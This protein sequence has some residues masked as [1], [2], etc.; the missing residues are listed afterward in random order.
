VYPESAPQILL[1]IFFIV[2]T[3]LKGFFIV[4]EFMHLRFEF[5]A[6][7]ITILAPTAFLI[8]FIIA[9]LWEGASWLNLREVWSYF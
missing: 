2:A 3:L 9:F 1:N 8:W 6:L 4:A 5:R 7:T